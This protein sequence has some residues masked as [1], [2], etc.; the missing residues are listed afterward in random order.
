YQF[1]YPDGKELSKDDAAAMA[2][3]FNKEK[4]DED[5]LDQLVLPK[6]AVAVGETWKLQMSAI[7]K[8]ISQED[9]LVLDAANASGMGKLVKA[10]KKDGRQFGVME[11]SMELPI[12]QVGEAGSRLDLKPGA[13]FTL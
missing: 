7:L 5:E 13:K 10:Y 12:K 4:D 8:Q 6:N 11:F 3:E 1:T 9:K 2:K